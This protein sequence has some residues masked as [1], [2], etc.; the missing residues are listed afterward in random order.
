[1]GAE[2]IE[3]FA[4]RRPAS[5]EC[6]HAVPVIVSLKCI[7]HVSDAA[8]T[9]NSFNGRRSLLYKNGTFQRYHSIRGADADGV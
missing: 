5:L 2:D 8:H 4:R 3:P 7:D 9:A 1:M 6:G